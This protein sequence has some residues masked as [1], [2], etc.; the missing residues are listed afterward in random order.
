MQVFKNLWLP[1][2]E[3]NAV[4]IFS[5]ISN[6]LSSGQA[7]RW[8][9]DD[10]R[11]GYYLQFQPNARQRMLFVNGKDLDSLCMTA[12]VQV[13]VC[14]NFLDCCIPAGESSGVQVTNIV[15]TSGRD[16]LSIGEY[17]L[18]LDQFYIEVLRLASPN[19]FWQESAGTRIYSDYLSEESSKKFLL[20]A[21]TAN[22]SS[23]ATHPSDQASWNDFI[24]SCAK[25]QIDGRS[26]ISAD[27]V[28]RLLTEDYFWDRDAAH[29]LGLSFELG[30]ELLKQSYGM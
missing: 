12:N 20:F 3:Q 7:S 6:C 27:I 9:V 29:N 21:Q 18:I 28:S 15:P 23:S 13:V 5:E 26:L 4:K 22:K 25:D 1:C 11:L 8:S 16:S 17:N 19:R 30:V 10:S 24:I 14:L 2:D